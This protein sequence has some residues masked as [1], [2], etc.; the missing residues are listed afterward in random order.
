V[1]VTALVL[2]MKGQVFVMLIVMVVVFRILSI[3][4]MKV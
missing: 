3:T 2:T 4:I 1:D